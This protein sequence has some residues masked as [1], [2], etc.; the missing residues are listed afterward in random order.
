MFFLEVPAVVNMAHYT[1]IAF[2][3]S[4]LWSDY[5]FQR[6]K[7]ISFQKCKTIFCR[8]GELFSV[9]MENRP[10]GGN[11]DCKEKSTNPR[12]RSPGGRPFMFFFVVF[13]GDHLCCIYLKVLNFNIFIILCTFLKFF[14]PQIQGFLC[15]CLNV[16]FC[17]YLKSISLRMFK[18]SL[19][20]F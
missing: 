5:F 20:I 1:C 19:Q 6:C 12:H 13:F 7:T 14:F 4:V 2:V 3:S 9:E 17:A 11:E 10:N 15:T 8:D 16:L 18:F